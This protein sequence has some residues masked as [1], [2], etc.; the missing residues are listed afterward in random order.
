MNNVLIASLCAKVTATACNA[1]F[2]GGS[3]YINIVETPARLSLGSGD[4]MVNHFQAT[5]PLAMG[6]QRKLGMS[7]FILDLVS[8]ATDDDPNR[9]LFLVAAGCH[10][11]GIF[12]W[13][14]VGIM[15]TNYALMGPDLNNGSDEPKKK[16]KAWAVEMLTK[17]DRA[18]LVRT[19]A[20]GTA[21]CCLATYWLN[22]IYNFL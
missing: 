3:A 16:G 14:A 13:T 22:K 21:L 1:T 8:F 11:T 15:P 17:W 20:S 6:L 9:W 12:I 10:L 19:V 2:F 18:H 5:F 4:A 7:A